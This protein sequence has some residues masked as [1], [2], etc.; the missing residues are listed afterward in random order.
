MK[1]SKLSQLFLVSS[2]GLLVATIFSA[3]AITTIDYVF[4]AC[5][6]GSGT[7]SAGQIQT[8]AVDSQSGALRTGAP[9]VA[10]GGTNP[11]SMIVSP[12]YAHLYVAN[13]GTSTIVHFTIGINGVLTADSHTVTLTTTPIALAVNSA[14]TYLYVVSCTAAPNTAFPTLS[15]TGGAT[16]TEYS[17]ASG[18]IGSA[19]STK[20]LSLYGTYASYSGDVLVPTGLTV[21]TNNSVVS[22]NA[23]YVTAYDLSAYNPGC[24]PTPPATSCTTSTANPGWVFGYTI[25]T[26]GALTALANPFEAGIKPTAIAATPV[27]TYL[28]VTDYAQGQLIGYAI[29]SGSTLNFLPGGP[30]RTGSE[31][32]AVTI[33]PRGKFMYVTNSLDSTVSPYQI[34]LAT[35][36]P[37]VTVNSTSTGGSNQTDTQ[38]VAVVIDPALGRFVYTANYLGN[39]VSGFRLDSTSGSLSIN[40]ASPYPTGAKPTAVASVPHGNYSTQAVTP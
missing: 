15:C 12:D 22:G 26:G 28:Y 31:P 21:L 40:Q 25:G 35:G 19:V 23:V 37:T 20:T 4:V 6:A 24:I 14:G 1:F 27:D 2:I 33:D 30:Y 11:V 18:V 34:D 39:S 8:Y 5:S 9:T 32:S 10:S 7:A 36:A 3:C 13:A 17:L 38:P 29:M 16:L